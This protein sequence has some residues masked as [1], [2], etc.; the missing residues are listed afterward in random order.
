MRNIEIKNLQGK[1]V[2]FIDFSGLKEDA[3]IKNL[4]EASKKYIRS[5]PVKSV[6]CLTNIHE[7][8]FNSDV[9]E[10]FTEFVKGNKNYMKASAVIGVIG[11][12]QFMFNSIM[13]IS[14]RDVKA[15]NEEDEAKNWLAAQ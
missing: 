13:K 9:K 4:I 8:H 6:Y 1:E 15:F 14:G 11:L 12:R 5:K 3:E 7:M 10:I 2:C